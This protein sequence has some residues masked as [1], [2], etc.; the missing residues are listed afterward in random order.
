MAKRN[1]N[2]LKI[3]IINGQ[4]LRLISN[5]AS[6]QDKETM[7]KFVHSMG[8]TSFED[9]KKCKE[10][11]ERKFSALNYQKERNMDQYSYF[12]TLL[13]NYKTYEPYIK[14]HKEQWVLKGFARK[15]YEKQHAIELRNYDMY[16]KV[17]KALIR[18]EDK[19]ILPKEWQKQIDIINSENTEVNKS[20]QK[21]VSILAAIEVL[22]FNKKDLQRMIE[23][24]NLKKPKEQSINRN[25]NEI[26]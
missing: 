1:N 25:K 9:F 12:R 13:D 19:R 22:Q 5:R 3:P 11:Y 16:R 21:T 7:E 26:S 23:N 20:L 24:E 2:R 8:W 18:G 17:I 14:N 15:K 6:Y 4:Y 10:E